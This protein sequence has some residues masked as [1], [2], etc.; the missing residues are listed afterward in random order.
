MFSEKARKLLL[1]VADR[2]ERSPEV[3]GETTW[4]SA[5]ECGTTACI[6]GHIC[7]IAG[8][9]P[10]VPDDWF[11]WHS[12]AIEALDGADVGRPLFMEDFRPTMGMAAYLRLIAQEGRLR[13]LTPEEE[14]DAEVRRLVALHIPEEMLVRVPSQ[15]EE[16]DSDVR[17]IVVHRIPEERLTNLLAQDDEP[18]GEARRVVARRIPVE[19]LKR[20][21]S[22]AEEPDD[23]ARWIVAKRILPE[24]LERPLT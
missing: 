21:P 23:V 14:P 4:C 19:R 8:V 20:L 1:M 10:L 5:T 18:D 2:I 15:Y 13:L 9:H 17:W 16:P 11:D 6:A 22:A 12:A 7:D 24:R 3:Y